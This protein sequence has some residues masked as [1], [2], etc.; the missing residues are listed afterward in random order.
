LLCLVRLET[1]KTGP[2]TVA[3]MWIAQNEDESYSVLGVPVI[4]R[5]YYPVPTSVPL[6]PHGDAHT[7]SCLKAFSLTDGASCAD[8]EVEF[9]YYLQ[10]VPD[11]LQ[12][13]RVHLLA[14]LDDTGSF[15]WQKEPLESNTNYRQ[16]FSGREHS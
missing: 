16:K 11:D 3:G 7:D 13:K 14:F 15:A 1:A 10:D 8:I 5:R 4:D 2:G 6:L 9:D 12:Q